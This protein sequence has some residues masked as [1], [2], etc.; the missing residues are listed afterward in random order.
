MFVGLDVHKATIS[1]ALARGERDGEVRHW[2]AIPNRAD[3][4]RKLAGKLR[5][6]GRQLQFCYEARPCGYGL[7]RQLTDLGHDCVVI[8]IL[9]LAIMSARSGVPARPQ[10]RTNPWT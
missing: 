2:G 1:V 3:H 8:P 6:D 4:V 5:G 7:H 10:M 9:P